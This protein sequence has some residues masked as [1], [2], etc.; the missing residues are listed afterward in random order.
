MSDIKTELYF[1]DLFEH[2][3]DLVHILN[4]QGQIIMVNP[5]WLFH[6]GYT[7]EEVNGRSIYDFIKTDYHPLFK[8]NRNEVIKG[9]GTK[10]IEFELI[11]KS[12]STIVVKGQVSMLDNKVDLPYTR[13]VLKDITAQKLIESESELIKLRLSKFFRHAPDAVIVINE[14]QVITEWNLKAELIFGYNYDDAFGKPLSDLIIPHRYREAHLQGMERF[15]TTGHGPVLNKTIEI[16]AMHKSGHEFPV[17]LSISNIKIFDEWMFVAF[18]TDITERKNLESIAAQKETEL[19]Q[20]QLLDQRK[21]NFLSVASHELRTPLTA[22]K[23]YGQL[24][25][26]L[27]ENE[28]DSKMKTFLI[29]MNEQTDKLNH[30]ISELMDL[31]KIENGKLSI[32]KQKVEFDKL[33]TGIIDVMRPIIK[34]HP[35]IISG[36]VAA[37]LEIDSTRIEQVINNLISNAEKYSESGAEIEILSYI[38]QDFLIVQVK[39]KGI[40]LAAENFEK[41][42]DRFF[43]V[44]EITNHVNGFGIGLFISSEIIKQH[45][46]H[47]WVESEVGKGSTFSFSLPLAD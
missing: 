36:S 41:I 17:S 12:G 19:L 31:S 6:L 39:D 11:T 24:A 23:G 35:I 5:S 46:G 40:G 14:K 28:P 38:K 47:I 9:Y 44:Q 1:R 25:Y 29:K 37:R 42:F 22:I 43:R 7:F 2:T 45:N 3:S 4:L 20:S 30:F 27:V 21:T 33:L 15:M 10:E 34:Q 18:I 26:S 13:A 16:S 8:N 32:N